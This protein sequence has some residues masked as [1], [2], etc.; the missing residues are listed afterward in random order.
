MNFPKH[1]FLFLTFLVLLFSNLVF[2]Q[3]LR[4]QA[5]EN[6]LSTVLYLL[7]TTEKDS[8]EEQ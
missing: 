7:S 6:P 1:N 3:D 8:K 5:E 4:K 2:S